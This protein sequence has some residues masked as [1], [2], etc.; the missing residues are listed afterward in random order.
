MGERAKGRKG[1]GAKPPDPVGRGTR[2]AEDLIARWLVRA[3]FEPGRARGSSER[4]E[5]RLN[6]CDNGR[7]PGYLFEIITPTARLTTGARQFNRLITSS[8]RR[9]PRPTGSGALVIALPRRPFAHSP[10]R[11]FALPAALYFI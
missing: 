2:R 9:V 1:D 4:L 3:G 7:V 8:A 11:R 6:R 5:Y 10:F